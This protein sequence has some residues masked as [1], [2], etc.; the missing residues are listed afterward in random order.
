MLG[1]GPE[2]WAFRAITIRFATYITQ[3]LIDNQ[4]PNGI[5]SELQ[6]LEADI[7][8]APIRYLQDPGA[9]DEAEWNKHIV[10]YEGMNWLQPPWFFTEHYFYRRIMEAIGYF[11][12]GESAKIDPFELSKRHGLELGIKSIADMANKLND[13]LVNDLPKTEILKSLLYLDLWGNQAD[14]SLWPADAEYKEK[15]DHSE[16][17]SGNDFLLVDDSSFVINHLLESQNGRVDFLNDNAGMELAADLVFA[18]YLLSSQTTDHIRFHLKVHPTFVSDALAKDVGATIRFFCSSGSLPVKNLGDRLVVHLEDE[19]LQLHSDFFW[20]SPLAG[21]EMPKSLTTEFS[22]SNL[23]ISKGDANYRR[24][25]GDRHW[26]FSTP[27]ADIIS[28]FPTPLVALRTLKSQ[29]VCGLTPG[30]AEVLFSEDPDW[31]VNGCWG[32]IQ[33]FSP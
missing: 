11:R 12:A 16:E 33:Y 25:L 5:V 6:A 32:I 30:Q 22:A 28:Y 31:L 20:N 17:A 9:P 3:V 13:W 27:F 15:P 19:R 7:P 21:W 8:S 18:D 1:L 10:P 26:P 23:V 24:L 4:F 14:Y 29:I 2:S